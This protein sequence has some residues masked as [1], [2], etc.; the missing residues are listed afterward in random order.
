[1]NNG[2]T[3]SLLEYYHCPTGY[4]RCRRTGNTSEVCSS[5]YYYNN[6]NLQ[7]VCDRQGKYVT[8]TLR[9]FYLYLCVIG[10]L[11]GKCQDGKGLSALLNKCK[12]CGKINLLL[13][14]ALGIQMYQLAYPNMVDYS[15][16]TKVKYRAN[17]MSIL[18]RL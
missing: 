5:V 17:S 16:S 3:N 1:M 10:I 15:I 13:I 4:C 7:C 14:P 8:I 18:K 12:S 9:K 6:E 2:S 11:C